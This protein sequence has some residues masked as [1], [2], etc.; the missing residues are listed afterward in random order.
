M[1]NKRS[2][3]SSPRN[4]NINTQPGLP[5]NFAENVLDYETELDLDCSVATILKLIELYKVKPI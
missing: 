1:L 5:E 2:N 4:L 3:P